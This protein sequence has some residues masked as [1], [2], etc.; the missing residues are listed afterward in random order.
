M[1]QPEGQNK[2]WVISWLAAL[3]SSAT[4]FEIPA[5]KKKIVAS[6]VEEL[7][8]P[9]YRRHYHT[10]GINAERL[11]RGLKTLLPFYD[12]ER[13]SIDQVLRPLVE[14][15]FMP[16]VLGDKSLR[17]IL[18]GQPRLMLRLLDLQSQTKTWL[19]S[20]GKKKT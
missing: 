13:E 14:F 2:N 5:L 10:G 9:E 17:E 3:F 12:A 16:Q 18:Q 8:N 6:C 11:V 7:S 15:E 20:Y 4:F 19:W 1:P